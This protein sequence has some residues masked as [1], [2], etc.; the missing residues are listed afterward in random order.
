MVTVWDIKKA[1]A[2]PPCLHN[3]TGSSIRF[4]QFSA[5][6]RRLLSTSADMTT[7]LW[8][9]VISADAAPVLPHADAYAVFSPDGRRVVTG[10]S[11]K[12]ARV[13]DTDTGR[14]LSPA[15]RHDEGVTAARFDPRRP[16]KRSMPGYGAVYTFF[17]ACQDGSILGTNV[18]NYVFAHALLPLRGH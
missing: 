11:D 2:V 8:D 14:P 16:T 13:W 17:T 3:G 18:G 4:L 1:A 15:L 12:A 5:D 7:R 6:G 9:L 10:S